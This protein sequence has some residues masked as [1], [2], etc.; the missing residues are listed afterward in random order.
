[1]KV[2]LSRE[3]TAYV[4][5]LVSRGAY[6]SA[7]EAVERAL[8]AMRIDEIIREIGP[9]RFRREVEI[10]VESG[11]RDG[12]LDGETVFAE[13]RE[14]MRL[15]REKLKCQDTASRAQ[16]GPTSTKSG[17]ISRSK[18]GST[19]RNRLSGKSTTRLSV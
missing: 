9:E 18:A 13:I 2:S 5:D 12:W 1:M 6:A 8:Q 19:A 4:K 15:Y 10:G 3:Q 16:R 14:Q 7:D 11:R 17:A